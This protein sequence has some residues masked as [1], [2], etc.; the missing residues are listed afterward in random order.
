MH[1]RQA[2]PIR[3]AVIA[4]SAQGSSSLVGPQRPIGLLHI[5]GLMLEDGG[6]PHHATARPPDA[7]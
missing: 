6:F 4:R 1:A 2:L 5:P 7:P 3:C